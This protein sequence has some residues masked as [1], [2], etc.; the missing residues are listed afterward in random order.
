[1]KRPVVLNVVSSVPLLL[2]RG[3]AKSLGVPVV[4]T[5]CWENGRAGDHDLAVGLDHHA[6]G[7][8]VCRRS[9]AVGKRCR[10]EP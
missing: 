4:G 7:V 10:R 9:R 3:T 8:V 2:N 5:P 6:V 1:M